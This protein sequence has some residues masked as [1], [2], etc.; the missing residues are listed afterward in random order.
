MAKVPNNKVDRAFGELGVPTVFGRS[1]QFPNL[2][3]PDTRNQN[4][5]MFSGPRPSYGRYGMS[6]NAT[7]A[8]VRGKRVNQ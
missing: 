7:D 5:G 1:K 6:P 8:A 4:N 2:V 3:N